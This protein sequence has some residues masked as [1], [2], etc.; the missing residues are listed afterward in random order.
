MI[1]RPLILFALSFLLLGC[2]TPVVLPTETPIKVP[3]ATP[4]LEAI[5]TSPAATTIEPADLPAAVEYNLGDTTLTQSV[6]PEDSR[7][8]NMPVRLNGILAVPDGDGAP[9]PV[10]I[11]LHG[12]HPG[13]PVP[14]GDTVDRWPC[15]PEAE[16]PNYRGFDFLVRQLAAQGYLALSININAENTFGFGEPVPIERLGQLVDMHLKALSAAS[17][18]EENKFGVELQG[19][20]DLSRMAFIGHSQGGEGAYWLTEKSALDT[21]DN[22]KTMVMDRFTASS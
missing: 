2:S 20:A 15:D 9:Y 18:G 6:F 3:A 5:E 8:R 19:R 11:I 22:F 13:C 12:N 14:E 4:T 7:F 17:S 21:A 10:V 16:R 1:R